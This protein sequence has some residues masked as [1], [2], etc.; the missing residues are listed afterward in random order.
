MSDNPEQSTVHN[1]FLLMMLE[2]GAMGLLLFLV[3]LGALFWYAQTIYHRTTNRFWK[4]TSA[5]I[6]AILLMECAVNFLS[7]MIETDK[8]GPV[9]YLCVA[10]LVL[11]DLHTRKEQ[12]VS[13]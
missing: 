5:A 11:A 8:A 4:I 10:V 2:Q 3:L 13:A 12:R 7:D 1:Y 9:F 6:A